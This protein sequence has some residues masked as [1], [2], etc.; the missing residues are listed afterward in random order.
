VPHRHGGR[1]GL[2]TGVEA[3]AFRDALAQLLDPALV[4]GAGSPL[5]EGLG[6]VG[7]QFVQAGEREDVAFLDCD[8]AVLDLPHLGAPGDLCGGDVVMALARGLTKPAQPATELPPNDGRA[9]TTSVRGHGGP[10]AGR[11]LEDSLP[12]SKARLRPVSG[13]GGGGTRNLL[14]LSAQSSEQTP[15]DLGPEEESSVPTQC[16]EEPPH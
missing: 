13:R 6:D 1:R 14:L 4:A 15:N 12:P 2:Q 3:E 5:H 11:R 9:G 16:V 7:L 8:Q 10:A